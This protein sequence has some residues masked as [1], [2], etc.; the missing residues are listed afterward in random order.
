MAPT[1][2][3]W[4]EERE[5]RYRATIAEIEKSIEQMERGGFSVRENTL[6]SPRRDVTQEMI[7][8]ERQV[9]VDLQ[10]LID[11]IKSLREK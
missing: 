8:R 7:D 11:Y 6:E 10:E 3:G 1:H 2:D 9:I 4:L 5:A